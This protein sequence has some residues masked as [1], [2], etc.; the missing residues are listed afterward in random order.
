MSRTE[1]IKA[2]VFVIRALED[3]SNNLEFFTDAE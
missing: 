2:A 1:G 3:I